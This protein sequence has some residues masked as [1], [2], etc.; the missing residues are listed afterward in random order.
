MSE[1]QSGCRL[2][3]ERCVKSILSQSFNHRIGVFFPRLGGR[4]SWAAAQNKKRSLRNRRLR[5]VFFRILHRVVGKKQQIRVRKRGYQGTSQFVFA[6]RRWAREWRFITLVA[7]GGGRSAAADRSDPSASVFRCCW[8]PG[9]ALGASWATIGDASHPLSAGHGRLG[10]TLSFQQFAGPMTLVER[11][12]AAA[13]L[14]PEVPKESCRPA[15]HA[16]LVLGAP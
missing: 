15:F 14:T 5:A 4:D 13:K 3:P 7:E 1:I 6:G 11:V 8:G 10:K 2:I 16:R 12:L 9:P